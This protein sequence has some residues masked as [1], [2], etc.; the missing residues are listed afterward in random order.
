[1]KSLE[2]QLF[3]FTQVTVKLNLGSLT[4]WL[5]ML[6]NWKGTETNIK[7]AHGKGVK[8]SINYFTSWNTV[9]YCLAPLRRSKRERKKSREKKK[10]C[11]TCLAKCWQCE[12]NGL[13][14][15]PASSFCSW[16]SPFQAI[17]QELKP[18]PWSPSHH[19]GDRK[20]SQHHLHSKDWQAGPHHLRH[21]LVFC[22]LICLLLCFLIVF[23]HS[24][25][26]S[27]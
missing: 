18:L 10:F 19:W 16:G 7:R 13:R 27:I 6:K 15:W 11:R 22:L 8:I 12:P 4:K 2:Q 23:H 14:S 3:N 9:I 24:G 26:N 1:M 21:E 17:Y 25:D 20:Q 5:L